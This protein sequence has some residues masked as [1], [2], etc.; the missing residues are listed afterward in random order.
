M[1]K[2]KKPKALGSVGDPI[3]CSQ[4]TGKSGLEHHSLFRHSE[5]L[6]LSVN[7]SFAVLGD[8]SQAVSENVPGIAK[9]SLVTLRNL[10]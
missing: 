2:T 7:I 10:R 6:V 4:P 1:I 9:D 5:R 8:F 3:M